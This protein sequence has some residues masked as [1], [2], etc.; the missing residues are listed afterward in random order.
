[1]IF[2]VYIQERVD[3]VINPSFNWLCGITII[4][5]RIFVVELGLRSVRMITHPKPLMSCLKIMRNVAD[6]FNLEEEAS[7]KNNIQNI[8]ALNEYLKKQQDEGK[9]LHGEI[10]FKVLKDV[11]QIKC[12]KQEFR[13]VNNSPKRIFFFFDEKG[14]RYAHSITIHAKEV[15]DCKGTQEKNPYEFFWL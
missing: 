11:F 5:K 14:F 7:Q 3:G 1:M 12:A 4:G 6:S 8:G 15:K 2:R 13:V 9:K 10:M